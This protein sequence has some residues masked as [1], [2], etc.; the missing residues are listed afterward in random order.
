[1]KETEPVGDSD[2]ARLA[3]EDSTMN[4]TIA[5]EPP[6]HCVIPDYIRSRQG[7]EE[8]HAEID[9]RTAKIGIDRYYEPK[10]STA[11][12]CILKRGDVEAQIG[13]VAVCKNAAAV[14]RARQIFATI[15]FK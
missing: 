11:T 7:Y 5:Y 13:L 14:S 6:G 2:T 8:T 10:F 12:A 1:M 3:Y 4:L 9:G 15:K